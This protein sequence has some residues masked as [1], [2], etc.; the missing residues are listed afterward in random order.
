MKYGSIPSQ[1]QP[2]FPS[3]SQPSKSNDV[4]LHFRLEIS[5]SDGIQCYIPQ[6]NHSIYNAAAPS[7]PCD[8]RVEDT[9]V[10]F[11]GR[12]VRQAMPAVRHIVIGPWD[13][14]EVLSVVD[15]AG[16]DDE[17]AHCRN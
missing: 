4:P 10:Q 1:P 6:E 9:I 12:L 2:S 16:F 17:N 14:N 5:P 11:L 8:N 7:N 3:D 15:S 13:I